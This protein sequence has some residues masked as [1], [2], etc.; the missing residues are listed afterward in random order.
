MPLLIKGKWEGAFAL[1][2]VC[3]AT[4]LS[5]PMLLKADDPPGV[6]DGARA[7]MGIP[8]PSTGI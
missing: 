7:G 1:L 2:P 4:G 3:V 6:T 5:L 8:K